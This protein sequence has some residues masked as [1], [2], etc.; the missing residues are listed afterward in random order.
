M[1]SQVS[2]IRFKD[3]T[4]VDHIFQNPVDEYQARTRKRIFLILVVIALI[5]AAIAGWRLF[6]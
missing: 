6:S 2:R 1:S 3:K 5:V 4:L